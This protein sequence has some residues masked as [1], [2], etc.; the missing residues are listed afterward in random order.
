M[1]TR[2]GKR[3]PGRARRAG[4]GQ[5]NPWYR[6][7]ATFES[8]GAPRPLQ[9]THGPTP[10]LH[11]SVAYGGWCAWTARVKVLGLRGKGCQYCRH[12]T[13]AGVPLRKIYSA[14]NPRLSACPLPIPQERRWQLEARIARWGERRHQRAEVGRLHRTPDDRGCMPA[15]MSVQAWNAKTARHTRRELGASH[16]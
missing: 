15:D 8:P 3:G 5:M 9:R 16:E 12:C 7:P 10:L 11:P 13:P 1:A 4:T 6:P 2:D 14:R